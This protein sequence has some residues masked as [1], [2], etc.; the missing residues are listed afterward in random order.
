M[1]ADGRSIV[2]TVEFG[3][4]LLNHILGVGGIAAWN[5]LLAR[6][7]DRGL[8]LPA[9]N[10]GDE[11]DPLFVMLDFSH[12]RMPRRVLDG[13]DWG[14]CNLSKAILDQSSLR[15]ARIGNCPWASFRGARLQGAVICGD[16]SG[17]DFTDAQGVVLAGSTHDPR[18]P[19]TGVSP[20]VLA[21]STTDDRFITP[22]GR[23][24]IVTAEQVGFEETPNYWP[25]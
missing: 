10:A 13:I 22:D 1:E 4:K 14:D 8:T 6:L 12:M 21:Q 17:A 11:V 18:H 5:D 16:V 24:L 23:H 19:P 25:T 2:L 7:V 20:S 9:W 3:W 15:N